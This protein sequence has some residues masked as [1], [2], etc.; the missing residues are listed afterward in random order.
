VT[1]FFLNNQIFFVGTATADSRINVSPKDMDSLRVLGGNRVIWLNVTES[2]N[3]A[4]VHVQI[5]PRMTIMFA[6]F[7]GKPMILRLYDTAKPI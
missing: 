1:P 4:A 6:A 2:G 5:S 7:K 3:E